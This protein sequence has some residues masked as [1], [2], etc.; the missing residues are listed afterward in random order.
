VW[1]CGKN[2][3]RMGKEDSVDCKKQ[4]DIHEYSHFQQFIDN[5]PYIIMT[6]L[7]ASILF[8]GLDTSFWK[9]TTV[10]LYVLYSIIGSFWIIVF[11]C[12]YCHFYDTMACPCGY[13]RMA[14]RI[15]RKRDDSLFMGKFRKNIPVLFPLWIVPVVAG[16]IFLA[17]DF[18]LLML[19]LIALFAIDSFV[20]LPLMSKKYGCAHCPQ[21]DECPWM[22]LLG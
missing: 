4:R 19:V 5:L 8:T 18:S 22:N 11:V 15:R 13:G 10:G 7:G 21:R 6:F 2:E 12:P 14:A 20:V 9:Y 3:V 16:V 1:I 17:F